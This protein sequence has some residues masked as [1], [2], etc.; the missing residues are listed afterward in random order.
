LSLL[1]LYIAPAFDSSEFRM[2]HLL[3]LSTFI[4]EGATAEDIRHPLTPISEPGLTGVGPLPE[5]DVFSLSMLAII[6]H[7]ARID[8]LLFL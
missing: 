3:H 2:I 7:L 8:V 1:D 4:L 5:D 6:A